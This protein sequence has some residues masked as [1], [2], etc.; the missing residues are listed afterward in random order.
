MHCFRLGELFLEKCE[1][2]C[3]TL[4]TGCSISGDHSMRDGQIRISN[5][6]RSAH[7]AHECI[8]TSSFGGR[9]HQ[10]TKMF[11]RIR[12]ADGPRSNCAMAPALRRKV[13]YF[14]TTFSVSSGLMLNI[15][16]V[17]FVWFRLF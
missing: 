14:P 2:E 3:S 5:Q 8:L 7:E 17:A 9:V 12:R 1:G 15:V 10:T 11:D 16:F 4:S 6:R 13:R